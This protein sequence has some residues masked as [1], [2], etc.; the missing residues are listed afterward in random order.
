MAGFIGAPQMNFFDAQLVCLEKEDFEK[1]YNVVLNGKYFPL[2]SQ[3]TAKL[4]KNYNVTKDIILGVRPEHI[5]LEKSNSN[6]ITAK[7]ELSEMMGSEIHVHV[8]LNGKDVIIRT[9][10]LG[11]DQSIADAIEKNGEISFTFTHEVMHLF[12]KESGLSLLR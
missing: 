1:E 2:S 12:D 4:L 5:A 7:V 8:K 6:A 3:S 10:V 11:L 9:P